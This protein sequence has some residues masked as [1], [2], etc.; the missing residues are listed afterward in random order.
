MCA[1]AELR[2]RRSQLTCRTAI[3]RARQGRSTRPFV[4]DEMKPGNL[5]AL[6]S[7]VSFD[8]RLVGAAR[9]NES[10]SDRPDL[11]VPR[12]EGGEAANVVRGGGHDDRSEGRGN[13]H[14]VGVNHVAA[15]GPGQQRSYRVRLARCERHHLTPRRNQ[16]SCACRSERL[17]WATPGAV[18]DGG[19]PSPGGP[20]GRPRSACRCH[21]PPPENRRRTESSPDVAHTSPGGFEFGIGER[22]M[23]GLPLGDRGQSITNP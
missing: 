18:T 20:D 17:T 15:S 2:S 13:D 1:S 9:A 4:G 21:P 12:S 5:D 23:L 10:T 11:Y 7:A 16:R 3:F 14:D 8:G 6:T 22:T 19:S